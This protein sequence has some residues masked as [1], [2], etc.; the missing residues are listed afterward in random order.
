MANR[1]SRAADGG[2]AEWLRF[3]KVPVLV[4]VNKCES[5]QQG[6][7]M[8]AEFW[9]LGLGEPFAISAIHGAG[10]GELLDHLVSLLPPVPGGRGRKPIQLAI[11][12]RP[13]VGKSSLLNAICGERR[14]VVS[15]IGG[16]TR[17]TIDTTLERG[18]SGLEAAGHGRHPAPQQRGIWA[19]IL[20]IHRSLKAIDRSDVCVL[21]IDALDGVT[22]QDQRAIRN[23]L[24]MYS[25]SYVLLATPTPMFLCMFFVQLRIANPTLS[26]IIPI[27]KN[28][29]LPPALIASRIPLS[30]TSPA[31]PYRECRAKEEEC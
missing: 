7:A 22:E 15:P 30:E 10:T 16:T 11:V 3:Q 1:A 4:A 21:V 13:N 5:P 14:A 27:S 23:C 17:D 12:G 18:G 19:R 20:G 28:A 6:L 24:S 8:A 26:E 9:T 31:N 25:F 2:V 29:S